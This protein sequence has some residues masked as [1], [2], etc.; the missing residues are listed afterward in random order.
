[1][2]LFAIDEGLE[3]LGV[4]DIMQVRELEP[5]AVGDHEVRPLPHF[6]GSGQG[7]HLACKRSL[8]RHA[9]HGLSGRE[10]LVQVESLFRIPRGISTGH[11]SQEG[12]HVHKNEPTAGSI[13]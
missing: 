4:Q 3:D 5:I 1:M 10:G 12:L 9:K 7:V 2:N 8:K 6:Q 13:G 11:R